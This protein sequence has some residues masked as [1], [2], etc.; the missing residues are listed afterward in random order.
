MRDE[1]QLASRISKGQLQR[2]TRALSDRDWAILR[3]IDRHSYATT[4]QLRRN[5]FYDHKTPSAATRATIRVLDRLL[6]TQLIARLER[7]VGGHTR[8]SAAY[9]WHLDAA[10]E[11]LTRKDGAPRRRFIDPSLPFL[12]HALQIAETVTV[13][14][15]IARDSGPAV[16]RLEVEAEAWRSFQGRPGVIRILKPD[17]FVTLSSRDFDDHWYIEID[18]GTESL[19]VLLCKSGAYAAYRRTGAA[20]TEH[21]VFPRVLWVLPTQRRLRRLEAAIRAD[22]ELPERL[23]TL[24]TPDE[25]DPILR[26]PEQP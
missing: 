6:T 12:E 10:G 8:G 13:L 20:Q 9:I 19:P 14:H 3:F 22:P 4:I 5:F 16:T 11:R 1:R 25:L 17:L 18:R 26:D 7:R 24:I 21:G 15:E 2:L 23:F